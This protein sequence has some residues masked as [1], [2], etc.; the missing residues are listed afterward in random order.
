MEFQASEELP[1]PCS[2]PYL[3]DSQPVGAY[4]NYLGAFK[5]S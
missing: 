4:W 3:T 5:K 1:Y 2:F